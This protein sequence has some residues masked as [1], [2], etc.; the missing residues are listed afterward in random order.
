MIQLIFTQD[1]VRIPS[2]ADGLSRV[3]EQ[4]LSYDSASPLYH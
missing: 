1:F 2:T 3:A 4:V